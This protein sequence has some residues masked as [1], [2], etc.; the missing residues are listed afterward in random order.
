MNVAPLTKIQCTNPVLADCLG[1]WERGKTMGFGAAAIPSKTDA[2]YCKYIWCCLMLWTLEGHLG[3]GECLLGFSTSENVDVGDA[4]ACAQQWGSQSR[5]SLCNLT[6][7]YLGIMSQTMSLLRV[8]CRNFHCLSQFLVM[9][10][11]ATSFQSDEAANGKHVLN[12]C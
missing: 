7:N 6:S 2:K 11:V 9:V 10:Q 12:C 5:G 3:Y 1:L 4:M 8:S